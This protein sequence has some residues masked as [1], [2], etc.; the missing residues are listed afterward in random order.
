M[1]RKPPEQRLD[2]DA[3]R[4]PDHDEASRHPTAPENAWLTLQ[5]EAGNRAVQRLVSPPS[6]GSKSAAP[7]A[8]AGGEPLDVATR[9]L[10]ENRFSEDLS[11]VRVHADQESAHQTRAADAAAFTTGH[12]IFFGPGRYAPGTATGRQLLAHELAHVIQ[13]T[14]AAE[15]GRVAGS[16]PEAEANLAA[17]RVSAGVPVAAPLYAAPAGVIA[18]SPSTWKADV[19]DAKKKDDAEALA[20]LLRTAIATLKRKVVVAKTSAGGN[21]KPGDYQ[22]LPDL[23]FDM[24]LNSKNSK[25][26]V[27]GGTT[28]SLSANYGYAFSDGAT[29][30]VVL[31]PRSLNEESPIFSMMHAEHE[32]Y[33]SVHHLSPA[34]MAPAGGSKTPDAAAPPVMTDPEEELET[35][36]EDFLNYFHQLR[37]FMPQWG[38]IITFYERAGAAE[39]TKALNKLK[40]YYNSPPS[41]PIPSGDVASVKQSFEKWLR[42]RLKDSATSSKQLIQDLSRDLKI[43]ASS[44]TTP[45]DA[46]APTSK[47][48]GEE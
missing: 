5:Q 7:A 21:I 42:R 31:G 33:H 18:R 28:H 39:R 17:A 22:P 9:D 29:K 20:G 32:L 12:D 30:Y 6:A 11:D 10:M 14:K 25:P 36:T 24:N 15:S 4:D 26:L 35:Y 45:P 43:T 48:G 41:P 37:G 40:A 13:Q 1:R 8:A 23:N 46:G 3:A 16:D 47:S 34:R 38:P 2:D 44:T 27:S 19:E